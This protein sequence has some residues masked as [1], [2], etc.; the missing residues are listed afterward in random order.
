M[1]DVSARCCQQSHVGTEVTDVDPQGWWEDSWWDGSDG[2]ETSDAARLRAEQGIGR[3]AF[4]LLLLS[5]H[6][7]AVAAVKHEDLTHPLAHY[8][9]ATSHNSYLIGDQ[10]SGRPTNNLIENTKW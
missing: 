5:S 8:W 6:N 7:N 1:L 4:A 2:S 9:T 10:L 3:Q